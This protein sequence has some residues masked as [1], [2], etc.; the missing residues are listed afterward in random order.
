MN[1]SQRHL[2]EKAYDDDQFYI[3]TIRVDSNPN[4]FKNLTEYCK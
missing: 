2:I 1:I 3:A 4:F